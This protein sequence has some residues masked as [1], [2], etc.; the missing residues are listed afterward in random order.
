[1]QAYSIDCAGAQVR[2]I[3]FKTCAFGLEACV[4]SASQV[5]TTSTSP[6]SPARLNHAAAGPTDYVC[7]REPINTLLYRKHH[8]K[9]HRSLNDT[10]LAYS[11]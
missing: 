1:M 3:T 7:S 10:V 6:T 4:D 11:S 2:T 9:S 5:S 8:G